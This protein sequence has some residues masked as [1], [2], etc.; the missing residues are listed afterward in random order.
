MW[1]KIMTN[2]KTL[3]LLQI[4]LNNVHFTAST[5]FSYDDV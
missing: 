2:D 1:Y 3:K 4:L 5:R